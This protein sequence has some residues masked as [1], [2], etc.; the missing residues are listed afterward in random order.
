MNTISRT[1]FLI[2]LLSA[3]L[4]SR[5]WAG[6]SSYWINMRR[7]GAA[8]RTR[9]GSTW[10]RAPFPRP[11][12]TPTTRLP[13]MRITNFERAGGNFEQALQA[14]ERRFDQVQRAEREFNEVISATDR[15]GQSKMPLAKQHPAVRAAMVHLVAERSF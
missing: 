9:W 14:A 5:I 7:T 2:G 12:T 11:A 3:P 8:S 15:R 6:L 4:C 13:P 10:P 1:I